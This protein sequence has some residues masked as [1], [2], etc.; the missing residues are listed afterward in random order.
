MSRTD[1]KNLSSD[2]LQYA[3]AFFIPIYLMD[4]YPY[5]S[6]FHRPLAEEMKNT[7]LQLQRAI[8]ISMFTI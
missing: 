2:G 8:P 6:S 7:C 3:H 1:R 5:I 4:N